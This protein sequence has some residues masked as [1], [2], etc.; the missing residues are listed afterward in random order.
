MLQTLG[1]RYQVFL[2]IWKGAEEY[3]TFS[4]PI[5]NVPYMAKNLGCTYNFHIVYNCL[6]NSFACFSVILK[7]SVHWERK[8]QFFQI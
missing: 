8:H 6:Q 1:N 3:V 2:Y 7:A 5:K 4:T